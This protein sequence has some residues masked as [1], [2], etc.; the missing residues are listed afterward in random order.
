LSRV[1]SKTEDNRRTQ[2]ND[3]GLNINK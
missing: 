2:R 1:A 3:A